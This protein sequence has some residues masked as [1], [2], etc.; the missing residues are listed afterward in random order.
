MGA[1]PSTI[2]PIAS[3]RFPGTPILRT[4]IRSSGAASMVAISAATGTPPRG[5][6][7]TAGDL[8]L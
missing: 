5:N 3:S 8:P 2:A 6:A 7:R 4:K 1:A